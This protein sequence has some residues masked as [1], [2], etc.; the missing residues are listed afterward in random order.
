VK[1]LRKLL[2]R[3]VERAVRIFDGNSVGADGVTMQKCS[4]RDQEVL[5]LV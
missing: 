2:V 1:E 5:E 3:E 4:R